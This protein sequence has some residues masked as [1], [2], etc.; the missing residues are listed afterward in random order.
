VPV[1]DPRALGG[2]LGGEGTSV[3][4]AAASLTQ[5][6]LGAVQG[7]QSL[8]DVATML[9]VT[10]PLGSETLVVQT[11]E[12]QTWTDGNSLVARDGTL[13]VAFSLPEG[14]GSFRLSIKSVQDPAASPGP[15][16]EAIHLLRS[17]EG[18]QIV[19]QF[20][21]QLDPQQAAEANLYQLVWA[22]PNGKFGDADDQALDLTSADIQYDAQ[23]RQVVLRI[24]LPAGQYQLQIK[25]AA[26]TVPGGNQPAA[27]DG[28]ALS[29]QL[30]LL[31]AEWPQESPRP[32]QPD[33]SEAEALLA[34]DDSQLE[35]WFESYRDVDAAATSRA[36]NPLWLGL[37]VGV[38]LLVPRRS[39][40]QHR[41]RRPR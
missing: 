5:V 22:G 2:S 12:Y 37:G 13:H 27:N 33:I 8:A 3:S 29:V 24:K 23:T 40:R 28:A 31:W 14:L 38:G 35:R 32:A 34:L 9:A 4:L 18:E 41:P 21:R 11:V 15:A 30:D 39:G 1:L 7:L 36:A 6:F 10:L 16:L 20:D 26:L 17:T 19:L 25:P